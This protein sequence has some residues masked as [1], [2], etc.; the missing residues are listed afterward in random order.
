MSELNCTVIECT[1]G[2]CEQK[3]IDFCGGVGNMGSFVCTPDRRACVCDAPAI[4]PPLTLIIVMS[5]VSVT[6]AVVAKL[7]LDYRERA[8]DRAR[9]V[10]SEDTHMCPRVYS[11]SSWMRSRSSMSTVCESKSVEWGARRTRSSSMAEFRAAA[12]V[13][14]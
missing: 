8:R 6:L 4:P 7:C 12:L 10:P 3:C 5:F 13:P 2:L 1:N 11:V 9:L 14:T